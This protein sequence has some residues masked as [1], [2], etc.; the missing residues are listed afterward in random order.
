MSD[1]NPINWYVV[2][3]KP[4]HHKIAQQNLER[5]GFSTFLPFFESTKRK[6]TK[7]I[8]EIKPVFPGYIFVSFDK[9]LNKWTKI[10][11]TKGVTKLLLVNST[12]QPIPADFVKALKLRYNINDKISKGDKVEVIKGPFVNLIGT[13]DKASPQKR[14]TL[15]FE[16]MGQKVK[17]SVSME[18]IKVMI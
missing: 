10:N 12:P 2:Q 16:L 8:S 11:N 3:H 4:N 15:L 1:T 18:D 14:V 9:S 17:T 7:F 6:A 5:Q 13:I